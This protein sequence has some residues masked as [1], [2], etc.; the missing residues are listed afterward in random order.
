M[1][2]KTINTFLNGIYSKEPKQ[3]SITCKTNVSYID[4]IKSLERLDLND[5]APEKNRG[6]RCLWLRLMA[7]AI[8]GWKVP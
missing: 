2:Q 1:T 5:Y 3:N 6:Y 7:L 4:T 8:F